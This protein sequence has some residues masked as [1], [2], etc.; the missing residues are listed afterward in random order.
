MW[1]NETGFATVPGKT[2][3]DQALW[4]AR[5]VP[6]FLAE[7]AVEH[8]GIYEIKDLRADAPAIGGAPNYHLG[9]ADTARRKKLAFA[10][11][12][13]LVRLLGADSLTVTDSALDVAVTNGTPGALHVHGFLRPDG[14]QVL[15]AW[16]TASRVTLRVRLPRPGRNAIAYDLD[17]SGRR[18]A[19]LDGRALAPISLVPGDVRIVEVAP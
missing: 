2:E 11:V 14:R 6:T 13:L 16:D 9:L 18:F 3:R 12:Q 4:W 17:G 5:A 8:V 19:G 1:I 7:P 15:V 10:T